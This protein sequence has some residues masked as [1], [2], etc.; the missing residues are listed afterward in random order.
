MRRQRE[1]PA[2]ELVSGDSPRSEAKRAKQPQGWSGLP[3]LS[4]SFQISGVWHLVSMASDNMTYIE[5]KGDLRLFIRNIQFLNNSNLQFDFH[6]MCVSPSVLKPGGEYVPM[7]HRTSTH[8][9]ICAWAS[10]VDCTSSPLR[11]C[12]VES[13]GAWPI[14][15]FCAPPSELS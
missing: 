15:V 1:V 6:I 7:P 5:E 13:M 11:T 2:L 3:P 12:M 10:G 4:L 14:A 9:H 8:S